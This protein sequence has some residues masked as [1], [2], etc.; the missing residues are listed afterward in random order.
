VKNFIYI[1]IGVII[2]IASYLHICGA[3]AVLAESVTAENVGSASAEQASLSRAESK[4]R[5]AAVKVIDMENRGH[6]SGTYFAIGD[7]HI[8]ITAAHVVAGSDI[9]LINGRGS[10][11]TVGSVIYRNAESDFAA[12]LIP[13]ME[14]TSPVTLRRTRL[15][16]DD[17]LGERVFYTGY[18]AFHDRL[19]VYGVIT[20]FEQGNTVAIMNSYAWP[21][22][23]GSGVFDRRGRLVGLVM[24]VDVNEFIVPQLTEDIVWV[25]FVLKDDIDNVS[26]IL[27]S[28]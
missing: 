12:I 16:L 8:V 21:G 2:A 14:G 5:D 17:L 23:S 4:S 1:A 19:F 10:D 7:H 26:E 3:E 18:P 15:D 27:D 22:S 13:E 11:S 9:F 20:G 24:A 25:T 28:L 6:G